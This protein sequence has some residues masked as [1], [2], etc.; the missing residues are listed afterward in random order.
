MTNYRILTRTQASDIEINSVL[1]NTYMLLGLSL[2]FSAGAA[3]YSMASNVQ[4]NFLVLLA[5]MFGLSFLTQALRN[6]AWGLLAVFAYTGFMGLAVGPVLNSV[7]HGFSNG[8]QIVMTAMGATGLIF[9]TL[10]AYVLTS[11]KDFSYLGGFLFAAITVAFI[12]SIAGLFFNLPLLQIVISGAFALISCGY[13]L[14]T[15]SQIING[16]ERNYIM[17]TI[18]LYVAIFNLFVSLLRLLSVFGG[19]RD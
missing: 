2:L 6:S 5:G 12:A 13:I 8:S 15:T 10:S 16:G 4:L 1:R 7:I 19:N 18:S 14:F 9:M 3:V 11:K 17:A